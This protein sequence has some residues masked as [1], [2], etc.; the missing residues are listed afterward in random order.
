MSALPRCRGPLTVS[1]R[2]DLLGY[3][4]PESGPRELFCG[5]LWSP[6]MLLRLAP[7]HTLPGSLGPAGSLLVSFIASISSTLTVSIVFGREQC[8]GFPGLRKQRSSP[9]HPIAKITVAGRG[10]SYASDA[11]GT[12]S[13]TRN[14]SPHIHSGHVPTYPPSTENSPVV[15]SMFSRSR[16][17]VTASSM[18]SGGRM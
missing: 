8:Q 2:P 7:A 14:S 15:F 5:W 13:P 12:I 17:L 3:R 1:N 11:G 10:L 4:V 16:S 18:W 9:N 6:F